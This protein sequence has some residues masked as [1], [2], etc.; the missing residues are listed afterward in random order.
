[1]INCTQKCQ[2][3]L[4]ICGHQCSGMCCDPCK[5]QICDSRLDG[6]RA[7]LKPTAPL[8]GARRCAAPSRSNTY[9]RQAPYAPPQTSKNS[10]S[11]GFG[12]WHAYVN[13]GAK[14]DDAEFLRKAQ[15]EEAQYVENMSQKLNQQKENSNPAMS[16]STALSTTLKPSTPLRASTP[17]NVASSFKTSSPAK[18]S[19][20]TK[21]SS[22]AKAPMRPGTPKTRPMEPGSVSSPP[23][24]LIELSPI[25]PTKA[26]PAD[27]PSKP[28]IELSPVKKPACSRNANLLIDLGTEDVALPPQPPQFQPV[29]TMNKQ[30][31]NAASSARAMNLLD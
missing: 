7:L 2:R 6:S 1:M 30:K 27:G 19:S 31:G 29:R 10:D 14:A 23:K 5:C 21:V 25:K 3:R 4:E 17:A 28:L 15:R 18:A 13:G 8:N 26:E 12:D 24:R 22:M 20:T 9:P 16:F 11:S